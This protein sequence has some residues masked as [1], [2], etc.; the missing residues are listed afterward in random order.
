MSDK[1]TSSAITSSHRTNRH[2]AQERS[3]D[4]LD[5]TSTAATTRREMIRAKVTGD[6]M[7]EKTTHNSNEN[8][9]GRMP[10]ERPTRPA[11]VDDVFGSYEIDVHTLDRRRYHRSRY[12]QKASQSFKTCRFCRLAEPARAK[13]AEYCRGANHSKQCTYEFPLESDERNAN[14]QPVPAPTRNTTWKD[15]VRKTEKPAKA[16]VPIAAELET[17][18]PAKKKRSGRTSGG[19]EKWRYYENLVKRPD[20][21]TDRSCPYCRSSENASRYENA[22]YCRGRIESKDCTFDGHKGSLRVSAKMKTPKQAAS[23]PA[24]VVSVVHQ[25]TTPKTPSH[26]V[27]IPDTTVDEDQLDMK[28]YYASLI[29]DQTQTGYRFCVDCIRSGDAQR[30]RL[31]FWCRGRI[32]YKACGHWDGDESRHRRRRRQS[33]PEGLLYT[34]DPA[35]DISLAPAQSHEAMAIPEEPMANTTDG[36]VDRAPRLSTSIVVDNTK[37]ARSINSMAT[38]YYPEVH[39][40]GHGGVMHCKLCRSAGGRR[41]EMSAYC[42]G[43]TSSSRCQFSFDADTAEETDTKVE[44]IVKKRGRPRKSLDIPTTVPTPSIDIVTAAPASTNVTVNAV[45]EGQQSEVVKRKRGRPRKTPLFDPADVLVPEPG[46]VKRK[47]GRPKSLSTTTNPI[48][49]TN[50]GDEHVRQVKVRSDGAETLEPVKRKHRPRSRSLDLE[51]TKEE[52]LLAGEAVIADSRTRPS[53]G[54]ARAG[55]RKTPSTA[56]RPR[57]RSRTFDVVVPISRSSTPPCLLPT[58]ASARRDKSGLAVPVSSMR[59]YHSHQISPHLIDLNA[60]RVLNDLP[61]S[62]PP[63]SSSPSASPRPIHHLPFRSSPLASVRPR[64]RTSTARSETPS[65]PIK[66]ILRQ[67]SEFSDTPRSNKRI[68]FSLM[69]SPSP[70]EVDNESSDDELLL[71]APSS[72]SRRSAP[73]SSHRH[74]SSSPYGP[75]SR[76]VESPQTGRLSS[77]MLAA[78]APT[79]DRVPTL[80]SSSS[81][82]TPPQRSTLSS[83][84]INAD[85]APVSRGMM[86]PPPV[87]S[88]GT[89]TPHSEP[90]PRDEIRRAHTVGPAHRPRSSTFSAK[91][92]DRPV[93]ENMVIRRLINDVR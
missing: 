43:R 16:D 52:D 25:A 56:T 26:S 12:R 6:V 79:L 44:P 36:N 85:S 35:N 34:R 93:A 30:R 32:S 28:L 70:I 67:S 69:R 55:A 41:K 14:L 76:Y 91:S 33:A 58:V 66:G 38:L 3:P 47:P 51:D 9:K 53:P 78:Y 24:K 5:E 8:G 20:K 83:P 11:V 64:N 27:G 90:R 65:L 59:N 7:A 73:P 74:G 42:R 39:K 68:R 22:V 72:T 92:S 80:D 62:S 50:V 77:S 40:L 86:A 71:L 48:T 1:P 89:P 60:R 4:D 75:E 18:T 84:P 13:L 15:D 2:T 19:L 82:Y 17:T 10:N 88:K 23:E 49:E 29:R 31:S 54:W 87:P 37:Q 61:P 57:S 46:P 21:Q 45:Q 63:A 81:M